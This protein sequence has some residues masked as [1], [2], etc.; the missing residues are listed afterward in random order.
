MGELVRDHVVGL[1]EI[2]E[3]AAVA[4][5]IGHLVAVPERIVVFDTVVYRRHQRLAGVVDRI[6][7]KQVLVKVGDG[8]RFYQRALGRGI[9]RSGRH[10]RARQRRAVVAVVNGHRR[11]R[12]GRYTAREHRTGGGGHLA[13][14]CS[15]LAPMLLELRRVGEGFALLPRQLLV[16][17]EAFKHIRG[18]DE[19]LARHMDLHLDN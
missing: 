6:A 16:L 1:G 2:N 10:R 19:A 8:A 13:M 3:D 11:R 17:G 12:D 4:V 15:D 7:A 9:G 5:A 18:N 14:R